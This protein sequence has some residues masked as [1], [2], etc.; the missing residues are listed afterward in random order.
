M[1]RMPSGE[2]GIKRMSGDSH[3]TLEVNV[4]LIEAERN[5]MKAGTQIELQDA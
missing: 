2:P 3:F 5:V 4:I 1:C